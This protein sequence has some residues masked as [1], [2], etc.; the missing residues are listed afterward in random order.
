MNN[1]C[2]PHT[3]AFDAIVWASQ[4]FG[5]SSYQVQNTFP[6]DLYEFKFE[7]AEQASLFALRWM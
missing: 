4:H 7:R 5:P 3:R 6:A 2:I 1:I